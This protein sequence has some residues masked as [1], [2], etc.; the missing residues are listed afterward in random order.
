MPLSMK[1]LG[2]KISS[3]EATKADTVAAACPGRQNQIDLGIE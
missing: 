3:I 2:H 1:M